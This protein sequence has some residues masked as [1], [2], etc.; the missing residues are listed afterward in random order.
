MK[1]A[2]EYGVPFTSKS[3]ATNGYQNSFYGFNSSYH[4]HDKDF[5]NGGNVAFL[6]DHYVSANG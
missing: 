5:D 6:G 3:V 2:Y 4:N 1:K